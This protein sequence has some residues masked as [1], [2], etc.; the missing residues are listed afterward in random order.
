MLTLFFKTPPL[1][2]KSALQEAADDGAEADAKTTRERVAAVL[3]AAADDDEAELDTGILAHRAADD[4]GALIEPGADTASVRAQRPKASPATDSSANAVRRP[5]TLG[6]PR[7][8]PSAP[9]LA[10]AAKQLR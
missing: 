3:G 7:P 9:A 8:S 6:S 2:A 10:A 1:R 5:S 4:F